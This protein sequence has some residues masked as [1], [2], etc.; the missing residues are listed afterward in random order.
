M[1]LENIPI[2]LY[3]LIELVTIWGIN[4]DGFRDE[5]IERASSHELSQFVGRISSLNIE[6]IEVLNN[7]LINKDEILRSTEEYINFSCFFMAYEYAKAVLKSRN[8]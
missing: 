8:K 3:P 4:D 2:E 5:K 1:K 6:V 7:W